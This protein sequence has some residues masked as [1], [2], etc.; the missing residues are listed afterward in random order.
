MA[1][2][3]EALGAGASA[4]EDLTL[5]LPDEI[6]LDIFL[7]LPPETLWSGVCEQVCRR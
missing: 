1:S 4:S 7:R 5:W 6:I 3:E 2:C